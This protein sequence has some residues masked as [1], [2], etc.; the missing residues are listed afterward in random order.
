MMTK[1]VNQRT[2]HPP[3]SLLSRVRDLPIDASPTKGRRSLGC[4]LSFRSR[5][6]HQ[7]TSNWTANLSVKEATDMDVTLKY[8]S[9]P[10]KFQ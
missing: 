5:E 10:L 7:G 8:G 1:R 6:V 4:G 9:P 3:T 2:Q